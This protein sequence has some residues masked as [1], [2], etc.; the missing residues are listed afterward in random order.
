MFL[1]FLAA[2]RKLGKSHGACTR[3]SKFNVRGVGNGTKIKKVSKT[4]SKTDAK[5]DAKINRNWMPNKA[6]ME[7]KRHPKINVFWARFLEAS[8]KIDGASAERR[9][10]VE[11]HNTFSSGSPRA[12]PY[13]QRIL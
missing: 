13:Y 2:W 11:G 12:A 8:G 5:N 3:A 4:C 7:P 1:I 6:K 10:S 9:G